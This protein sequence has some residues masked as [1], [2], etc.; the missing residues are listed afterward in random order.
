MVNNNSL[1]YSKVFNA[2][3]CDVQTLHSS[4]FS[5]SALRKTQNKVSSRIR[6]EGIGFLT[7]TLPRL[8]KHFDKVLAGHCLFDSTSIGFKS[9]KGSKLPIFIGEL[10]NQVLACDGSVLQC[11]DVA[12]IKDIRQISYLFYKLETGYSP[13]LEH[14]VIDKFIKTDHELKT[15][16]DVL[17]AMA[18]QLDTYGPSTYSRVFPVHI[19]KTVRKA[20]LILHRLFRTFDHTD[21]QPRHGPGTV[22]TRETLWGKYTWSQV[23]A[24]ITDVYPLDAYFYASLG[25]VCDSLPEINSV[26]DGESPA[27]VLLVPK[28]SR[29]PRLISCEPLD[30][31]WIQQG[32]G[33][34]IVRHVERHPLTRESVRF[35]DQEPNRMAAKFGSSSGRYATL[36]LNEASDRVSLGLVRLLFPEPVLTALLACR[37]LGTKLPDGTY[38]PLQ[39][40]APMGSALCFPVLALSVWALLVSSLSVFDANFVENEVYVY[41]DDVIVPTR[42]VEHAMKTLESFGLKINRDKSCTKGFFRE[43]CGLDAYKGTEVTPVRFRTPWSSHR[44]PESYTSWISYANSCYERGYSNCGDLIAVAL[45]AMYGSIPEKACGLSAPSLV[46]VPEDC[47]PLRTRVNSFLQKKEYWV[48]DTCPAKAIKVIDGWKMLLRYFV[49]SLPPN[50]NQPYPQDDQKSSFMGSREPFSVSM[51]TYRRKMRI[52]RRWQ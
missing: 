25:H 1:E 28:D 5:P 21:I 24:R 48:L 52:F 27:Q 38:M 30:F 33:R 11:A 36:D 34:A 32:L 40:Y 45:C 14:E 44:C 18:T 37:S 7:K 51:Y 22:S 20:R 43:S 19:S 13:E 29:G 12:C 4:V 31:Q 16:S 10:F 15:I 41:G 50:Y 6:T 3:L 35:T 49:E 46:R 23:S 17:S 39:K 47:R 9:S 26:R 2:L 42:L 8:G